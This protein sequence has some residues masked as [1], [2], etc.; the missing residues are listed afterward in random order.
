MIKLLI[1]LFFIIG[2]LLLLHKGFTSTYVFFSLGLIL[3]VIIQITT[4]TSVAAASSGLLAFD[5][6]EAL[7]EQW[8]ESFQSVGLSMLPILGYSAY[9]N[10]IGASPVLSSVVSKPIKKSKSPYFVGVAIAVTICGMMRIVIVSSFTIMALLFSTLYP[11]MLKA[12]L[13]KKTTISAI[14]LGSCFDWG[15][16]DLLVEQVLGGANQSDLT[17]YFVSASLHVTPIA[18]VCVALV[19]GFIMKWWDNRDG[20]VIGRDAPQENTASLEKTPSRYLI[21]PL[22]P[23][24]LLIVFS[25]VFFVSISFSIVTAVLISMIISLVVETIYKRNFMERVKDLCEWLTSMGG[26]FSNLFLMVVSIQFFA[27]MMDQMGGFTYLMNLVIDSGI[28]GWLMIL[29]I[30][31]LVMAMAALMGDATAITA[32]L[33][34]EVYTIAAGLG[35]PFYAANLPMQTANPFRCL[36]IGTGVH[37]QGC[38][39]YASC[40][41]I[42]ILKRCSIPCVIIFAIT[43]LGS[44]LILG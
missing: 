25:K 40:S 23:M 15:P 41:S 17:G 44:M 11:A 28:S 35:I 10:K 30:S 34:G 39:N 21:L 16:A 29:V 12:G 22:L 42:D 27:R 18:L 7:K 32:V 43:Y 33:A 13:S 3:A 36:C 14:Y 31:L 26:V 19:S 38:A 9:M 5:I 4:G 24:I 37:T 20:Y 2:A 1:C 8:I 6:F